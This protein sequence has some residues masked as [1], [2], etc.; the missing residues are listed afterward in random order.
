MDTTTGKGERKLT[1]RTDNVERLSGLPLGGFAYTAHGKL[2]DVEDGLG[3]CTPRV[4]SQ[5]PQG[6]A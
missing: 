6:M 5:G 4:S 3:N 2:A 1:E